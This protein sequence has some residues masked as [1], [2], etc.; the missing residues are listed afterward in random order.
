MSK[1]IKSDPAQN[2]KEYISQF[3][4]ETQ[5]ALEEVWATIKKAMPEMEET[6]SYAIPAFELNGSKI[7]YFAGYKNHV[8]L[9]PVPTNNI[10]FEK[11]FSLYKTSGKGA[12]QFPLNQPMPAGLITRIVQFKLKE[13]LQNKKSKI[14][15]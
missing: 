2:I 7:I 12:I 1:I 15:T 10:E 4:K 9:Y 3:P 5:L 13:H 14:K 6:I 11:D 8:G